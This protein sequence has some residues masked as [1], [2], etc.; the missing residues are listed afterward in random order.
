MRNT[1]WHRLAILLATCAIAIWGTVR[2]LPVRA[3]EEK[4]Q[5]ISR[6][7]I[8][9][10]LNC[11][12]DV[13]DA[14]K[15]AHSAHGKLYCQDCH[16]TITQF[17]HPP[18]ALGHLPVCA[19]CHSG[20][21]RA[22]SS[23]VHSHAKDATGTAMTCKSCHG[24]DPHAIVK[25]TTLT[26]V[27][28]ETPCRHCHQ[29]AASD[30][31]KSVHGHN[32]KTGNPRASCLTCHG[33]NP[34]GIKPPAKA[35]TP[36][37]N[38]D[39][40]ACHGADVG[41]MNTQA[42]GKALR[43]ADARLNCLACH[44]K[45][46]HAFGKYPA[47]SGAQMNAR[48]VTCH[49][50]TARML[51]NSAHGGA[52]APDGTRP[53]CIACHGDKFHAVAPPS[54]M[55]AQDKVATCHRCHALE[56]KDLAGSVHAHANQKTGKVAPECLGCHGDGNPHAVIS[57]AK[58]DRLQRFAPCESCHNDLSPYLKDTVHNHPDKLPGDHPTCATCHGQ[59]A[60]GVRPPKHLS[61]SEKVEICARCHADAQR[62]ARYGR[63]D[64]VASYA[65][66]YHGRAILFFGQQTEATCVDCHGL[67]GVLAPENPNAPTNPRHVADICRKCHTQPMYFAYSYASHLRL[68]VEHSVITPLAEDTFHLLAIGPFILLASLLLLIALRIIFRARPK[69]LAALLAT[70]DLLSLFCIIFTVTALLA[71]RAMQR[72]REPAVGWP[73][74]SILLL[75][76]L[77]ILALIIRRL[78]FPRSILP[79]TTP[80]EEE[81]E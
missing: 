29:S 39:C 40:L 34:H 74:L 10:C 9:T 6:T 16:K 1:H 11:H 19:S 76:A 37:Q 45:N 72:F 50:D 42:H 75:L 31:T 67:H 80:R 57:P 69:V 4:P 49:A 44:G 66:T 63:V 61:P 23:S 55:S 47:V 5:L 62:M 7:D 14:S 18:Q 60:H 64:A 13:V 68:N 33:D 41:N 71:Q 35:A 24:T 58:Q 43:S 20:N 38:A 56:A 46:P 15:F 52:G 12:A 30:W 21:M 51:A 79:P 54:H 53:N 28:K 8:S 26:T 65:Q 78:S 2:L 73:G 22:L 27:Q 77:A 36:R 25:P 59:N 48:C 32:G 81:A 3:Q 17:P 70:Y